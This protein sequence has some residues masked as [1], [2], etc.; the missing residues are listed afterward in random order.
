MTNAI[1]SRRR[2]CFC[3][4]GLATI[5]PVLAPEIS[6]AEPWPTRTVRVVVPFAAAGAVDL[7]ARYVSARLQ[8]QLGQSFVVD[9]RPGAG[10]NVGTELVVQAPA[11]GY[12][13]LVSGLPTHVFNPYLYSKLP[14]DP[15]RDLN[16][17]AMLAS[18]PNL[19]VVNP[20]LPVESVDDLVKLARSQPGKISFA[21]AGNGTSGHLAGEFLRGQAGVEVQHVPFRG[22][23]DALTAVIRGDVAFAFVAIPGTLQLVTDGRLRAIA[24]TS[25]ERSSLVPDV[26]TVAQ[27]GYP[28]FEVLAWYSLAAPARTPSDVIDVLRKN[29]V[30]LMSGPETGQW[31]RAQ[32][33]EAN[34]RT[35]EAFMDYLRAETAKWGPIIRA[36][37]AVAN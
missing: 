9:N 13:L 7:L 35:G 26:L 4:A 16:H 22:Q 28:D 6:R 31:L 12:T 21:S 15:M 34:V 30:Q 27:A 32:G 8:K 10:G 23:A 37:G 25:K 2:R 20:Q 11:D 3:A 29:V 18:A 17:V 14:F 1:P 5:L 19:L 24:V 36:S 33:L